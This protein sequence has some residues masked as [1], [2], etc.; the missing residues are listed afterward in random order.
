MTLCVVLTSHCVLLQ[1][2]EANQA[3]P[4]MELPASALPM[5]RAIEQQMQVCIS[6]PLKRWSH[7]CAVSHLAVPKLADDA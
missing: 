2:S 3:R 7:S 1:V 6:S 4:P 5:V